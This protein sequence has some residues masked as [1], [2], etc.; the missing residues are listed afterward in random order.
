M[1]MRMG[2][3]Y[4]VFMALVVAATIVGLGWL[5]EHNLSTLAYCTIG[6]MAALATQQVGECVKEYVATSKH[7]AKI[8]NEKIRLLV[9]TL[10]AAAIATIAAGVIAPFIVERKFPLSEVESFL[11][12]VVG[13]YA[14]LKA[15]GLLNYLKDEDAFGSG[16]PSLGSQ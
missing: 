9:N 4:L 13:L 2:T 11:W 14:H 3:G 6:S 12:L 15:R 7:D 8:A 10:N 5:R 16:V 1:K